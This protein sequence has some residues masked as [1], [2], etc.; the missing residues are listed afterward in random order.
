MNHMG[1]GGLLACGN[2]Q[3]LDTCTHYFKRRF[4][5]F[6]NNVRPKIVILQL[7]ENDID[8]EFQSLTIASTLEEIAIMLIKEYNVNRFLCVNCLHVQIRET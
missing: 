7:G 5:N 8:S 2:Y 4:D 3:R 1:I 6:L